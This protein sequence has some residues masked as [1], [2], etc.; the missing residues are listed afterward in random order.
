MAA[1]YGVPEAVIR[2]DME[3]LLQSINAIMNEE[4][5]QAPLISTIDFDPASV[6]FPVLSEIAV[7]YR[8]QNR[9]DFCYASSPYRGADMRGDDA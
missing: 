3:G 1:R 6:V 4:Y 5:A 9:C 8:C 7:T 2:K